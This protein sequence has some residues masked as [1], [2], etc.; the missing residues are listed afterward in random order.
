[1]KIGTKGFLWNADH[2]F[3][4][5]FVITI[6]FCIFHFVACIFHQN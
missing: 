4:I 2:E 3:G 6:I 1:M 5:R